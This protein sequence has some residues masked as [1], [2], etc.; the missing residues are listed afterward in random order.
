MADTRLEEMAR[1]LG[2]SKAFDDGCWNC[3]EPWPCATV[4]AL[5]QARREGQNE[6]TACQDCKEYREKA[7]AH[8]KELEGKLKST[9]T[10]REILSEHSAMLREFALRQENEALRAEVER[11]RAEAKALDLGQAHWDEM[12]QAEFAR[13]ER[14][15]AALAAEREKSE[16][17]RAA[18]S[19]W[20]P[21][22]SAACCM[23]NP[24]DGTFPPG[25]LTPNWCRCNEQA[26]RAR[27]ALAPAQSERVEPCNCPA[28]PRPKEPKYPP[29]T[30]LAQS[31]R[32]AM[33]NHKP[34]AG[35]EE[36]KPQNAL[37]TAENE[38]LQAALDRTRP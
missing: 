12:W 20:V 1:A 22:H 30:D 38:R 3:D 5:E 21:P 37:L 34:D 9:A 7:E 4:R 16:R 32:D 25:P 36:A 19:E 31:I 26:K 29:V 2:H 13:A 27:A 24:G 17:L 23:P 33:S 35:R 6:A 10:A 28:C 18:L 11:L 14:A 8:V 15:E